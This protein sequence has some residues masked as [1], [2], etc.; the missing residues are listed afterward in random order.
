MEMNQSKDLLL[1]NDLAL[2][3]KSLFEHRDGIIVSIVSNT[4]D[5]KSRGAG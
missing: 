5:S 4:L 1:F 2:L 3:I